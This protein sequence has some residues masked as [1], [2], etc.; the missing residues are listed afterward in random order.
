MGASL[1]SWLLQIVFFH[2]IAEN[3]MRYY[4]QKQQINIKRH[5][6]RK[7]IYEV[8]NQENPP[9]K[10]WTQGGYGVRLML[11]SVLWSISRTLVVSRAN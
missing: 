1:Y 9:C 8:A 7:T 4:M 11:C 10:S 2:I 3:I 5:I 6:M